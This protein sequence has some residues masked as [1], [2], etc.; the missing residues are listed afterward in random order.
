M[1]END[2]IWL[3]CMLSL[4]KIAALFVWESRAPP[5]GAQLF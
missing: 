1:K 5:A 2:P 3:V 4:Q